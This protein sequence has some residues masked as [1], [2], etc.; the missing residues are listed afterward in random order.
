MCSVIA[1]STVGP[2]F[3]TAS[4]IRA[5]SSARPP[6]ASISSRAT[7]ASRSSSY[8]SDVCRPVSGS[9]HNTANDRVPSA[10]RRSRMLAT[11][12][13]GSHPRQRMTAFLST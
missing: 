2:G 1:A 11:T 10:R 6:A 3:R 9:R 7:R 12:Q 8:V 13:E 5:A 4:A